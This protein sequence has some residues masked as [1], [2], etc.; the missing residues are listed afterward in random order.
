M[1]LYLTE[2]L[3]MR[4]GAAPVWVAFKADDTR[5]DCIMTAVDELGVVLSFDAVGGNGVAYPWTSI[6]SIKRR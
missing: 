4:A 1:L 3:R 5:A 2:W 6:E